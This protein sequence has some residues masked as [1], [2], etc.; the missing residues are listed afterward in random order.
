LL[1]AAALAPAGEPDPDAGPWT[2]QLGQVA[3][4]LA[5]DVGVEALDVVFPGFSPAPV[6]IV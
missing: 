6:G 3:R 4:L 5:A 2:Q 1:R